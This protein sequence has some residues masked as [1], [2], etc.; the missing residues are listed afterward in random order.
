MIGAGPAGCLFASAAQRISQEIGIDL[1]I[2]LFDGKDFFQKGPVGC[3][4]CASMIS[5]TTVGALSALGIKLPKDRIQTHYQG[6][7]LHTRFGSSEIRHHDDRRMIRVI[8]RGNLPRFSRVK[9][10]LSLDDFLLESARQGGARV[11]SEPVERIVLPKRPTQGIRV[12]YGVGDSLEEKE[13]NLAV[14]AFGLSR[15]TTRSME[16][17][18]FGYK[19]PAVGTNFQAQ[20]SMPRQLISDFY[21]KRIH[22]L[23]RGL[24]KEVPRAVFV[25]GDDAVTVV[26]PASGGFARR[27]FIEFLGEMRAHGLVPKEYEEDSECCFCTRRV[28]LTPA[29]RPYSSRLV[30]I[31]DAAISS[32]RRGGL[33]AAVVTAEIAARTS[34]IEG[35]DSPSFAHGYSSQVRRAIARDNFYGKAVHRLNDLLSSNAVLGSGQQKLLA[36]SDDEGGAQQMGSLMWDLYLGEFPYKALLARFLNPVMLVRRICSAATARRQPANG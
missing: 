16:R 26:G 14:G 22:I 15:T 36:R 35:I 29:R 25:P 6:F 31:G 32:F 3:H 27:D 12:S 7:V 1:D 11:V 5:E 8:Y 21:Q 2:V 13:F 20:L 28:P 24:S 33:E 34:L 17:S 30:I 10:A 19:P 23:E 9:G 4:L 18:G